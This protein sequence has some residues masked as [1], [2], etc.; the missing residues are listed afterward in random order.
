ML[1]YAAQGLSGDAGSQ[2]GGQ[3]REL[4]SRAAAAFGGLSAQ[5]AALVESDE[6]EPREKYDAFLQVLGR[7]AADAL[8]AI[9]LVL[10][11]RSISS[12]LVDNLN[13]SMHIRALLTDIFLLD[14]VLK[15]QTTEPAQTSKP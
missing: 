4:L 2:T 14:E 3:L 8:A 6:L 12:Q 7:D 11:Q 10:A 13:A 9:E 5:Y 15:S 1:A